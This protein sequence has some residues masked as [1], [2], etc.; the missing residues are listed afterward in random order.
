MSPAA[1]DPLRLADR[2]AIRALAEAYARCA[3]RRLVDEHVALF[4]DD[5]RLLTYEFGATEPTF[6]RQGTESLRRALSGLSRYE[7]TFHQ[8]GQTTIDFDPADA[9]RATAETYCRAEHVA[10]TAGGGRE[11]SIMMIRYQ[12]TL[13]RVDGSWRFA[14]RRLEVD[15]RTSCPL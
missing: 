3:D 14:E 2:L 8:L 13:V 4:T 6:V 10:V 11:N 7:R 9:D 1:D 15:W 5:G 12:D